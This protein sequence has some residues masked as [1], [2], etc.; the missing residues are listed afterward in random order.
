MAVE[1]SQGKQWKIFVLLE[2]TEFDDD[3]MVTLGITG[4]ALDIVRDSVEG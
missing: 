1:E 3:E 2:D 4:D